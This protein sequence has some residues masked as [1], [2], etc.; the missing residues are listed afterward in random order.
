MITWSDEGALLAAR[1]FGEA[2]MIIEVFTP[3]HG[4]HAGA[5]PR[6]RAGADPWA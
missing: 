5:V 6:R 2:S 1:P 3:P 4:R